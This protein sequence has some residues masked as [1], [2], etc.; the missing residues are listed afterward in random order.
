ML[1][2]LQVLGALPWRLLGVLAFAA[3]MFAV[4]CQFGEQRITV[5]WDAEKLAAAK[6]AEQQADKVAEITT[7][8][9][10]INQEI[11]DDFQTKANQLVRMRPPGRAGDSG[12]HV[13]TERSTSDLSAVSGAADQAAASATDAVPDSASAAAGA[14]CAQLAADAAQTTL[15]V[16]EFQRWYR[17]QATSLGVPI[18][19]E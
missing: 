17:E 14:G 12:V 16:L 5:R 9:S 6:A 7:D 1:S 11:S 4:G 10:T 2:L 18:E 8:Q 3:V 13:S 19:I 15:M